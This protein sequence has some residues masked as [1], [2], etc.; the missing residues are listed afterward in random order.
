MMKIYACLF[1]RISHETVICCAKL[2][3]GK[4]QKRPDFDVQ[5][6]PDDQRALELLIK[7]FL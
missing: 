2:R 1:H 4:N 5:T 7:T 6:Q 3:L